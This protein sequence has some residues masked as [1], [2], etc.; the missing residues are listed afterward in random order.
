MA[1]RPTIADV[2]LTAGVSASAVSFAVN[3]RPGVSTQTRQRIL[4]AADTLGWAPSS[5]ARALSRSRAD[6][7]GLVM[8]RPPSLLSSDP[9]FPAFIS[10]VESELEQRGHALLLQVVSD[11]AAEADRYR[12]LVR[13]GRVDGVL[14]TDLRVHDDRIPLLAELGLPAV[15]L[16]RP[17]G[18]SPVPAVVLDDRAGITAVVDHLVALGHAR[19]ALVSGP[20]EYVHVRHRRDAWARALRR[21]GLSRG[22][23]VTADF[24]AAGGAA[25]TRRLLARP[26]RPTAVVF[27]NDTSAIGGIGAAVEAG[28]RVPE[29]LSVTGFDDIELAAAIRP[30]LTTVRG[31]VV[32]WGRRATRVLLDLIDR[33]AGTGH[34][35]RRDDLDAELPPARLVVRASTAAPPRG[36]APASGAAPPAAAAPTAAP[37]P[38][39]RPTAPPPPTDRTAHEH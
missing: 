13:R 25:A 8:R 1:Q 27:L 14:L 9:F 35:D 17:D 20:P 19:V 3:G 39:L 29:D 23:V 32:A 24:T 37:A 7:V 28:L 10:G 38:P 15:T 11:P 16:G 31:D 2:A 26:D 12:Q 21:H 6:A 34:G 30:A 22:P 18:P 5:G 36:T 33:G 4:A